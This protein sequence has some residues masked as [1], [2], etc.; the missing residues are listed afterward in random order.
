[1]RFLIIGAGLAAVLSSGCGLLGE[2]E[3]LED[4]VPVVPTGIS[5]AEPADDEEATSTSALASTSTSTLTS[6][7]TS[8]LASTLTSTSTSVASTA[9]TDGDAPPTDEGE[10]QPVDAPSGALSDS[11]LGYFPA[12]VTVDSLPADPSERMEILRDRLET[13]H[14][15]LVS[16]HFIAA[17]EGGDVSVGYSLDERDPTVAAAYCGDLVAITRAYF[18]D[19]GVRSVELEGWV[20]GDDGTYD[21]PDD[22]DLLDCDL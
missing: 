9:V 19:R 3:A 14:G 22:W 1:M 17:N 6:T 20:L 5:A 15:D 13:F 4:T 21:Y 2:E 16:G 12:G 7:S 10:E 8:A 18:A 11:P